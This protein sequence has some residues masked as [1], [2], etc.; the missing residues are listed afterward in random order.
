[1]AKLPAVFSTFVLMACGSSNTTPIDAVIDGTAVD[2][3]IFLDAPADAAPVYDFSCAGATSPTTSTD[4]ITISGVVTEVGLNGT[5]PTI[6]PL[7]GAAVAA[8]Q[9]NCFGVVNDLAD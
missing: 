9:A 4:P 2:A 7:V 8:C 1:M 5:T 6:T 3:K